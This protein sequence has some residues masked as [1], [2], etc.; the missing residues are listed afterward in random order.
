MNISC[1]II[2]DEP[3]A[4]RLVGSYVQKI[5]GL[6]IAAACNSAIDAF[7]I[8]R[9]QKIDLIFL[10]IKMPKLIGTD[11][12][13]SIPNPPKVIFITAYRDYAFDGYELDIIDYLLKPVSF[14][15]FMKAV[16]KASKL[17]S[18]ENNF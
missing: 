3:L 4:V 16:A 13:R 10:D 7:K 18:I 14:A 9:E 12:L 6:E 15:R 11:F 8:L 1:L 5:P 2:D 17:I